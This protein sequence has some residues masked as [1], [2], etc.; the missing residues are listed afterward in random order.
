[1]ISWDLNIIKIQIFCSSENLQGILVFCVLWYLGS[2]DPWSLLRSSPGQMQANWLK[3]Q[4]AKILKGHQVLKRDSEQQTIMYELM[5]LTYHEH[6]HWQNLLSHVWQH[7]TL[8]TFRFRVHTTL[9]NFAFRV[10]CF[11][12]PRGQNRFASFHRTLSLKGCVDLWYLMVL[13]IHSFCMYGFD[14][15]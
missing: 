14:Q 10:N 13:H 6:A 11:R 12:T 8:A 1:M 3:G 15:F 7:A 5:V 2:F 4:P 9:A